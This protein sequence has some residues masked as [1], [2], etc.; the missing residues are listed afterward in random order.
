MAGALLRV[1][2]MQAGTRAALNNNTSYPSPFLK[3]VDAEQQ[4]PLTPFLTAHPLL[5]NHR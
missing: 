2:S 5:A 1:K 4:H 3:S